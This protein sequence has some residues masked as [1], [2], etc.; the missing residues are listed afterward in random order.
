MSRTAAWCVLL[1]LLGGCAGEPVGIVQGDVF[2]GEGIQLTVREVGAD[3]EWDCA[4]GR[5][6]EPFRLSDEGFFDLDGTRTSGI[7]GPIREDDPPRPEEARYR[8]RV[9]G[10]SMT[11]SVEL[12][13]RGL[14]LGP[15]GLRYGEEGVLRRCL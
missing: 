14:T 7:G 5:I 3:L 9:S 1:G 6:E 8:G 13:A 12:P 11:L 15:Y 2:G 10:S 4:V